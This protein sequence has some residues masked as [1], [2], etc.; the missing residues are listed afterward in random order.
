MFLLI[1]VVNLYTEYRIVNVEIHVLIKSLIMTN[2]K[3]GT[4]SIY[5]TSSS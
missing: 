3:D 5:I 1:Y 2:S 4:F